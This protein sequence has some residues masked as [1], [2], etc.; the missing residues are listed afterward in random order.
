MKVYLDNC[1]Y[2][3]PYDDQSHLRISLE[4]QAKLFIQNLIREKKIELVT[5][6]VLFYENSKN[7][8]PNRSDAIFNFFKN[9]TQHVDSSNN[10]A[11][12]ESAKQIQSAGIKTA[13]A[14][15]IACAELTG[16]DYFLTT[17]DRI[18]KYKSE[19]IVIMNPIQ[20]IQLFS[21]EM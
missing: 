6:Y 16:C 2:N 4:T 8:H 21:E 11:V 7:P 10:N 9:A 15:H 17:D 1:C 5:S 20:F 18:L 19:K 12:L 3:R 13:D 14:C